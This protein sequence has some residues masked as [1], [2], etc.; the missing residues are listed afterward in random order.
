MAQHLREGLRARAP[1]VGLAAR[2]TIHRHNF[3]HLP[4]LYAAS[5]ELGLD[6][7]SFLA[8]DV[9]ADSDAFNRKPGSA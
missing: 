5:R 4:D 2:A 1:H 7:I 9:N 6:Q 3:R 8:A